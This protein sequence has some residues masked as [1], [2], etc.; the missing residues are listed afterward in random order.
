M[1][2]CVCAF[3]ASSGCDMPVLGS[4]GKGHHDGIRRSLSLSVCMYVPMMHVSKYACTFVCKH[5]CAADVDDG[6]HRLC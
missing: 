2:V 4:V 6:C 3:R 5:L 1:C